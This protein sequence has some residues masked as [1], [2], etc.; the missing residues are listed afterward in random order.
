M[1]RKPLG[2]GIEALFSEP[3]VKKEEQILSGGKPLQV[4]V[5]QIHPN[6]YQPRRSFEEKDL[7]ELSHS[8][9]EKGVI[10]PLLVRKD[11]VGYELIAGERRWRAAMRAGFDTVPV[12][13]R[14]ASGPDLLELALVEN[15]QRKDLNQIE[16]AKAYR[17]L[18]EEFGLTQEDI[19]KR[20]GK[21]R[22]TVTNTL[23]LL[24]LP[25]FVQSEIVSGRLSY[26]HAKVLLSMKGP[27]LIER[28]ARR[29]IQK[30]LSV[31]ETER[32]LKTEQKKTKKDDQVKMNP[33]RMELEDKLFRH[34]GIK[35][36][37]KGAHNRGRIVLEYYSAEELDRLVET[38]LG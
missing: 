31:R 38:L 15:I 2:K 29:V 4:E 16:A 24:T 20:V 9:K 13:V 14:E 7:S 5:K 19:A 27:G 35:V 30:G 17:Q 23:R 28:T 18:S 3:Q 8:L 32:L 33:E 6:P 26:G 37:V 11:R 22:S 12:V 25:S 1:Q 34:L 36:R 10:Q 21:D